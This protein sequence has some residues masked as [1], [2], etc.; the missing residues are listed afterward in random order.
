MAQKKLHVLCSRSETR[1]V[2]LRF[3][4][5]ISHSPRA[6]PVFSPCSLYALPMLYRRSLLAQVWSQAMLVDLLTWLVLGGIRSE[7]GAAE[8]EQQG[9]HDDSLNLR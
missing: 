6:L 8:V 9:N 3:R 4:F 1:V 5:F 2:E 7:A